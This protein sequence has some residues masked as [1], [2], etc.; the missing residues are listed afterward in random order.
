M[1]QVLSQKKAY[2]NT[3][4]LLTVT[5]PLW[6]INDGDAR[7]EQIS[8]SVLKYGFQNFEKG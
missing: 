1:F 5:Q 4:G 8:T 3:S 2:K 7:G 6:N